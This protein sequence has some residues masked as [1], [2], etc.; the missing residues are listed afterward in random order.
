MCF[1][2]FVYIYIYIYAGN[3]LLVYVNVSYFI[4][5]TPQ[6]LIVFSSFFFPSQ[7]GILVMYDLFTAFCL[8]LICNDPDYHWGAVESQRDVLP[9]VSIFLSKR[10]K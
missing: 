1:V 6:K 9:M 10:S 2:A 3:G 5:L 8:L 4:K 7:L